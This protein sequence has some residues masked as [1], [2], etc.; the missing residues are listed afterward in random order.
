MNR[1]LFILCPPYSG[2]TL[3]WKLIGTS[4]NVSLLPNEGQFLPELRPIMR[5]TPWEETVLP[6]AQIKSVWHGYWDEEKPILVEKS[7]SHLIRTKD[8]VEHFQPISFVIMVRD[9]YAHCEGMMRHHAWDVQTAVEFVAMTLQS[10]MNNAKKLENSIRFTY[11]VF[12]QEPARIS[13]ELSKFLPELGEL[14]YK[15]EFKIHAVD[16][17]VVRP[18]TNLNQQ[19]IVRLSYRQLRMINKVLKNYSKAMEY[20]GYEYFEPGLSHV[21]RYWTNKIVS[22]LQRMLKGEK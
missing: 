21:F 17:K 10:Q 4:P 6:W 11:E 13:E 15:A 2:S 19:K 14:D 22:K 8:L 20:W 18:I 1:Y 7:P 9:P 12:T 5:K 16:G 3:L